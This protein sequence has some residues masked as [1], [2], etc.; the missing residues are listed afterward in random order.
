MAFFEPQKQ[1]LFAFRPTRPAEVS[2]HVF[3]TSLGNFLTLSSFPVKDMAIES[4]L[5]P[6][7]KN[8]GK[9]MLVEKSTISS[10][11][12][13]CVKFQRKPH[14]QGKWLWGRSWVQNGSP[15]S[16]VSKKLIFVAARNF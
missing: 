3:T 8:L 12:P 7:I 9:K 16:Q 6:V 5:V 13:K 2:K 14:Q 15:E 11:I 1:D 10:K 4:I